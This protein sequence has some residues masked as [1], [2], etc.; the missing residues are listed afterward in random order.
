M[1]SIDAPEVSSKSTKPSSVFRAA[2]DVNLKL[3]TRCYSEV[4]RVNCTFK[5][6]FPHGPAAPVGSATDFSNLK[7]YLAGST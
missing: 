6:F 2:S 4:W 7:T 1:C 5:Q 3:Q